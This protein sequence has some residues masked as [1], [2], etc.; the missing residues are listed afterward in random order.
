M[1][2]IALLSRGAALEPLSMA[3]TAIVARPSC[4]KGLYFFCMGSSPLSPRYTRRFT[5]E[6]REEILG[7]GECP[8]K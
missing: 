3:W 6:N 2:Q 5:P 7:L 8:R 4:A 1:R